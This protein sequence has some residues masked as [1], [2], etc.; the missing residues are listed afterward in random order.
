MPNWCDTVVAI[1]GNSENVLSM[2]DTIKTLC[3]NESRVENGFGNS[4]EGN[5]LDAYGIDWHAIHCRGEITDYRIEYEDGDKNKPYLLL[6]QMDAWSPNVDYLDKV[7]KKAGYDL[8]LMFIAE[9]PGSEIYI[10]TDSSGRFLKDKYTIDCYAG[11]DMPE[12]GLKREESICEYFT[13]EKDVVDYM[14]KRGCKYTSWNQIREAFLN[15]MEDFDWL[16]VEEFEV[17]DD[18]VY[19]TKT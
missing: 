15:N 5:V 18:D 3:N 16:T 10:T 8:D 13:S 14:A 12:L 17:I 1:Y 4:W 19:I 7:I 11:K 6:C 2:Y 9:E